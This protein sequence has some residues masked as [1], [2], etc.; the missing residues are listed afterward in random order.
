ME[1]VK[2]VA[3]KLGDEE[4][5]FSINHVQSIERIQRMTRVPKAPSYV[6]GVIN[7]RGIITMI[8]DLRG[9]LNID[10]AKYD[11]NTRV[12]IT[13]FDDIEMGFIVDQTTDVID[14]DHESIEEASFNDINADYF[15]GVAKYNGRMIILLNL[16]ELLKVEAATE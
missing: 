12:I 16:E 15:S 6:K 14:V 9:K 5:G 13:K 10:E 1:M 7:L 3:F 8:M 4:F 2:I 11:E